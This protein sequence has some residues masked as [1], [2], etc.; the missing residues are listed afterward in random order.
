M[1]VTTVFMVNEHSAYER[2]ETT[3]VQLMEI[4]PGYINS[5]TLDTIEVEARNQGENIFD[6][7]SEFITGTTATGILETFHPVFPLLGPGGRG[8]S[9]T[10]T[11]LPELF[12]SSDNYYLID[13]PS[14]E[15]GPLIISDNYF[16][17]T[18]SLFIDG[19]PWRRLYYSQVDGYDDL[20]IIGSLDI[21][22]LP[23]KNWL[24]KV[25]GDV[26]LVTPLV[27]VA[28]LLLGSII[29]RITVSPVIRLTRF[30]EKLAAG[31]LNER[32][33]F[34]SK[35]ELGRLAHSLNLMAARLQDTFN[36]QK[37]FVSD[38]AHELKTPLAS[39]K[40]AVTGALINSKTKEEYHQL[41][42]FLS[43]KIDV[44]ERL[45]TDLLLQAK[46]DEVDSVTACQLV[47]IADLV[48]RAAGEFEPIFDEK[49]LNFTPDTAELPPHRKLYVKGDAGQLL[50]LFSN[51]F[52][53]AAKYTP[54]GGRVGICITAD[55]ENVF[56]KVR[57]TGGGIAPEHLDKIFDRFYKIS[58]DRTPESGFGLGLSICRGIAVRHG[59][60]ITV[61]SE[62][63]E[64]SVFTVRLPLYFG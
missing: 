40:T 10:I 57:D 61:E 36:S 6:I 58:A 21:R 20:V 9:T 33:G 46:A 47:D 42:D 12:R 13:D 30:S 34:T 38:A 24:G 27:M 64:G 35:D 1:I 48:A 49:G 44:Q 63:G 18:I 15:I 60:E 56:I 54:A 25:P 41:I 5:A 4:G 26:L 29:T 28:A 37:K 19:P 11:L 45:I 2:S 62:P 43:R 17:S 55:D 51:L 32:T 53:N 31:S 22:F 7:L 59:G 8:D 39:M 14:S 23:E 50:H 3:A 52:D 16:S